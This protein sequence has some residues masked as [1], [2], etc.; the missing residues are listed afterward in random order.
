MN[1]DSFYKTL[2]EDQRWFELLRAYKDETIKSCAE[3]VYAELVAKQIVDIRDM[4]E[5]LLFNI[6]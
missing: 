2:I 6:L 4:K 1:F 3:K 5:N